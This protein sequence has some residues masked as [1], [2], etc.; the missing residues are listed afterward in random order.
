MEIWLNL[1]DDYKRDLRGAYATLKIKLLWDAYLS[2]INAFFGT[3]SSLT[4]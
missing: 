4:S 1:K 2:S 3:G